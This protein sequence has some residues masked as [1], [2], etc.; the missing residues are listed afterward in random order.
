[1]FLNR[2]ATSELKDLG[3]PFEFS[4][5]YQLIQYLIRIVEFEDND[6]VLDFFAGSSP[7]AQAVFSM[8]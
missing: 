5:P 4:K 6:I 7:S 8:K 3:V 2:I 1:M